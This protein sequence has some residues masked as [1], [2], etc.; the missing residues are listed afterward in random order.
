MET[1]PTEQVMGWRKMPWGSV[2]GSLS[3]GEPN[4]S[5]EVLTDPFEEDIPVLVT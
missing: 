1:L 2:L 4:L 3:D 5:R